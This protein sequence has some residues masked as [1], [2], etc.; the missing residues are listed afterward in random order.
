MTSVA[1]IPADQTDTA[2]LV[3]RADGVVA[4]L[5]VAA[6]VFELAGRRRGRTVEVQLVA[7]RRRGWRA[8]TCWR[9]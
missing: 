1:T 5:A 6:A 4:G 2:D 7:R 8:A 9:R 3:A